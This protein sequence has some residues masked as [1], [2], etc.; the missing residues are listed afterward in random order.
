MNAPAPGAPSVF[1]CPKC[2]GH[3]VAKA[4]VLACVKCASA[5]RQVEGYYDFFLN[6]RTLPETEYPPELEPLRFSAER[7]L[8]LPEP[9]P[10]RFLNFIFRRR[11]FNAAW[12]ADLVQLKNTVKK[13]G[14]DEKNRVE[15]MEDDRSAVDFI[16]QKKNSAAKAKNILRTVMRLPRSGNRVLHVG[17]GGECNEAIPR[18]YQAAGFV[19]Y[20]VDAVR[21]YVRE[22]GA[23][24]E[25]QLANA[26]ALPYADETF[27]V[28]NFTDIL[29][30][31]FD[32]LAG[33]REASRVLK[34]NGLLVLET[35]NRM[36]LQRKNPC[37]WLEYFLGRLSPGLLRPRIITARWQGEVLFHT[38]FT[39]GELRT[40]LGYSGLQPLKFETEILEA[41]SRETLRY[42]LKRRIVFRLERIAPTNKWLLCARKI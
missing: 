33:L 19:N 27:D 28:V 31:L 26:S 36:Y 1:R 29:E 14:A 32:P 40:L 18:A 6:D 34:K 21:S 24:G 38:Q 30:H 8:A 4:R 37:S 25:A 10:S 11:R 35:P 13:Y 15:F 17:C 42:R 5:F 41:T 7:I 39:Q 3:L 12:A 22:F 16:E 2:R 9:G 23:V 20:G